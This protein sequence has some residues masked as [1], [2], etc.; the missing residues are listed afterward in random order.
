MLLIYV[1]SIQLIS[2]S[3]FTKKERELK[4]YSPSRYRQAP[5]MQI[6]QVHAVTWTFSYYSCMVIEIWRF[7]KARIKANAFI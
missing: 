5:T 3:I 6:S 4:L 2:W 7:Q 1:R